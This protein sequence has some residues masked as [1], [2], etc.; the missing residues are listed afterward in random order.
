MQT[1]IDFFQYCL[2]HL[3]LE[4][5]VMIGTFIEEIISPLPSFLVLVP[6]GAAAAAREYPYW[7]LFILMVCSAVGRIAGSVIL[8]KLADKTEDIMLAKKGRFFGAS[9]Q[10]IEQVGRRLGKGSARD[11]ISLFAL[12]AVPIFPTAVLSLVCGFLKVNFKMF[13]FCSFFGTMINAL[14]F[15]T[16]GYIGIHVAETVHGITFVGRITTTIFLVMGTFW[17]MQ[18]RR[19]QTRKSAGR[20]R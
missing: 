14:I 2:H 12:N 7:L 16:I 20:T 17:F 10:Q 15:M 18:Y 5:F 19:R 6:A 1:I 8:Y 3:P 4:L 9:H 11:W 13:A